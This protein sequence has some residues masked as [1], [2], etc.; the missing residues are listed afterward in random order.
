MLKSQNFL[1]LI[2]FFIFLQQIVYL[3]IDKLSSTNPPE[4]S[5]NDLIEILD[6]KNLGQLLE[7]SMMSAQYRELIVKRYFIDQYKLHKSTFII[8]SNISMVPSIVQ[9]NRFFLLTDEVPG[10]IQ[11]LYPIMGV[12]KLHCT[13][14]NPDLL[15]LII[16][17]LNMHL[18]NRLTDIT[19]ENCTEDA[20]NQFK[21]PF[22]NV[23]NLRI[24][25]TKL[26]SNKTCNFREAFPNVDRVDVEFT[27]DMNTKCLQQNFTKLYHFEFLGSLLS[28]SEKAKEILKLNNHLKSIAI[29]GEFDAHFLSFMSQHLPQLECLRFNVIA[30]EFFTLNAYQPAYFK[31]LKI[32][33]ILTDFG[34]HH[35]PQ[36]LPFTFDELEEFDLARY[37]I[38]D[39]WI[40]II[41]EN[42]KLNKVSITKGMVNNEQWKKITKELPELSHVTAHWNYANADGITHLMKSSKHLKRIVFTNIQVRDR[43]A[44]RNAIDSK[45]IGYA[46]PD[47]MDIVFDLQGEEKKSLSEEETKQKE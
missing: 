40:D 32:V 36:Q 27:K 13:G 31:N 28:E 3:T 39:Q 24:Q 42:K 6:Q 41:T 33:I 2:L 11:T 14:F 7:I 44:L 4:G 47:S 21:V 9:G 19:F 18:M 35:E 46:I 20:M 23:G 8:I 25:G 30:P 15:K 16:L 10:L 29:W 1:F 43:K 38:S 45:W 26:D 12:V 17:L 5:I 34:Y 22:K 37:V